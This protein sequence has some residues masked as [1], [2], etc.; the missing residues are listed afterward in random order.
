MNRSVAAKHAPLR[1]FVRA[2]QSWLKTSPFRSTFSR[3]AS[4]IFADEDLDN[5]RRWYDQSQGSLVPSGIGEVSFSRSSGPGGQNV[6]K[7]AQVFV[8]YLHTDS[9]RVNSKAQLRV[10]LSQLLPVVPA[11]LHAGIKA[12]RY[13]ADNSN[14]LLIQADDSRKQNANKDSCFRKLDALITDV[15]KTTVPG[16]TSHEQKDK[17][18]KLRKADNESRLRSKK[19]QSNKKASRAKKSFD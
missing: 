6:N 8:P 13:F 12:S 4:T 9:S 3:S 1:T 14:S 19:V 10:P 5:A 11:I 17:V 15:Y 18:K 16:E 7:Y 2:T